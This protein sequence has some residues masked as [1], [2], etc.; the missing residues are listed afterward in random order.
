MDHDQFVYVG[1]GPPT[2]VVTLEE[3][4]KQLVRGDQDIWAKWAESYGPMSM[5]LHKAHMVR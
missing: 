5:G 4:G 1:G 2:K 3:R